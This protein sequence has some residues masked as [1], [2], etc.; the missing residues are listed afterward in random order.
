MIAVDT[1]VVVRLVVGDDQHELERAKALFRDGSIFIGLSVFLETEW[2]LRSAYGCSRQQVVS[3][4]LGLAGLPNVTVEHPTVLRDVIMAHR[5][6]V[7]FADALHA[8]GGVAAGVLVFATFDEAL[9]RQ[10]DLLPSQLRF[11]EL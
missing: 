1:N 9:R 8:I 3:A 5:D 10:S 4:F 2:V 7:D 6:G 11:S